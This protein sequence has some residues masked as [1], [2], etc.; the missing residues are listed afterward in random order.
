MKILFCG[1]STMAGSVWRGPGYAISADNIPSA[2]ATRLGNAHICEN[3]GVGGSTSPEWLYGGGSISTTWSTRMA[4]TDARIVVINTSIND[5]F[6]P[7]LTYAD[8]QWCYAEFARIT[9]AAGKKIVFQAP[10]PI[11]YPTHIQRLW[12]FQNAMRITATGLNVPVINMWDVIVAAAPH[13][14]T[15]LPDAIHPSDDLYRL[16]GHIAYV[17]LV[18]VLNTT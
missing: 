3:A 16:M 8:H 14:I 9:R 6:L 4:A 5:A 17:G 2:V 11:N 12:E 18:P 1:D 13:W 15:M 10:N 7:G